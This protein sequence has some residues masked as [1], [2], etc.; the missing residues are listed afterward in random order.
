MTERNRPRRGHIPYP[1][2]HPPRNDESPPRRTATVTADTENANIAD[3]DRVQAA[4][5]LLYDAEC[6][7]HVAHQTHIEAWI[8]AA[9]DRLQHA[10]ADHLAAVAECDE[11]CLR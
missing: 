2:A 9:S 1:A 7:L 6:A 8:A 5:S 11:T 3:E 4:A 10:V